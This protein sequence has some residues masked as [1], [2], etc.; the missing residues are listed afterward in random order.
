M[1]KGTLIVVSGFSGAGKGTLMKR[2]I[3]KYDNYALS[4]SA[5]SREPRVGEVN[6]REYFFKTVPEFK[7][8]IDKDALIEYAVYNG[9]Y[10]G[11]PRDFVD[12]QIEAGKNVLL[13]IEVQGAKKIK[14]KFPEAMLVF[15][16]SPSAS[17]L[18]R[19]L[20]GRQTETEQNIKSRLMLAAIEAELMDRYD[21]VLINDDVEECV[22]H[23]HAIAMHNY[24][25]DKPAKDQEFIHRMQRDLKEITK[26]E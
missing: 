22:D 5:T 12:E 15:I 11:T 3:Q 23:L 2:L 8:M 16:S 10:Y 13:E 21:Y 7:E 17:E 19:R 6:G 9:N 18:E 1:S 26:G 14:E 24:N 4:I 20:K 25:Y